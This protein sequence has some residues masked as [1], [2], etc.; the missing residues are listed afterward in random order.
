MKTKKKILLSAVP[1]IAVAA[2]LLSLMLLR[3]G[4]LAADSEEPAEVRF[5]DSVYT[6][7]SDDTEELRGIFAGK[8]LYRD[9]PSCGFDENASVKF[10]DSQTFCIAKDTCPIVYWKEKDEYIKKNPAYG[11]IIC[12]CETIS[13][14][15]II[16]ALRRNPKATDIDGVKRRTRAGMGR[17]QGGFCM[18]Y[19]MRLIEKET[20]KPMTEIT[21]KGGK[22]NTVTGR[23]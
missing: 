11:R 12:R 13:E 16:D 10:G 1:I 4:R 5:A 19:V 7:R 23:L 9:N 15:E 22:S 17:C 20:G 14:G 8:R 21:K 6:L 3:G 2:V 18:P